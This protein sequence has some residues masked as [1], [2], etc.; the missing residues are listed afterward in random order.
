VAYKFQTGNN[1]IKLLTEYESVT[2]IDQDIN[3][4]STAL[5]NKTF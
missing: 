5:P 2:Q 1:R 4:A 3:A